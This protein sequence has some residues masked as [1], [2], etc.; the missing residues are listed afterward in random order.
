MSA[1][2]TK[3]TYRDDLLFVRFRGEADIHGRV[4]S[5]ASVARH[6]S[7]EQGLAALRDFDPAY[8]SSGLLIPAGQPTS[9]LNRPCDAERPFLFQDTG[10]TSTIVGAGDWE[11]T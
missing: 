11:W 8:D 6:R 1:F 9:N 7:L 10:R 4:A 5:T 3:R 2:G